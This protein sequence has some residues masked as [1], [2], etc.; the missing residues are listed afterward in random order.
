MP[1][2][3]FKRSWPRETTKLKPQISGAIEELKD[4][5][6]ES[7]S[8]EKRQPVC[9]HCLTRFTKYK[10]KTGF[11][12]QIAFFGCRQCGMTQYRME[13]IQTTVAVLDEPWEKPFRHEGDKLLINM[14]M[15]D[16]KAH[17]VDFDILEIRNAP[18]IDLDDQV[19]HII[20][21]SGNDA[22]MDPKRLKT[23]PVRLINDPSLT[24][25][26]L[27]LIKFKLKGV[28]E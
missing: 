12:K 27:N 1:C 17:L 20:R 24:Q 5:A 11:M 23:V 21:K 18:E 15:R 10:I 16:R 2:S 14:T 19:Q 6:K 4:D 26:T 9:S 3:I 7:L 22:F 8:L 25:N 13:D 28:A